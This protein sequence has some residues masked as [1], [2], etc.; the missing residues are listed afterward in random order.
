MT[1]KKEKIEAPKLPAYVEPLILADY[2]LEDERI[3]SDARIEDCELYNHT[4]FRACFDRV[5]FSNVVVRGTS[6]RRAEFT[7]VLFDNCDLSNMDLTEAIFHRVTFRSCKLLG[8]DL[9]EATLRNVQFEQC[10]AD[11]A[12]LRFAD[13][14]NVRLEKS[15]FAKA[16]FFKMSLSHTYFY[17]TNLDQA[18]FSQTKLAGIDL[19]R[20]QFDAL[21]ATLEDLRGCIIS[22]EQAVVFAALFGLVVNRA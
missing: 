11:Y 2:E 14:K 8:I 16:D 13:I 9:S 22:P 3:I 7:D 20:C 4:A 21:G 12:V 18:Q 15:S 17:D 19:S 10:Y 1:S 6:L 5:V